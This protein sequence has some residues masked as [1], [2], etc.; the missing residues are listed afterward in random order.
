MPILIRLL[1]AMALAATL[2]ITAYPFDATAAYQG[3]LYVCQC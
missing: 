1:V 2:S 3:G